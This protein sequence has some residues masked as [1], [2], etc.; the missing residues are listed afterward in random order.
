MLAAFK[1]AQVILSKLNS[2]FLFIFVFERRGRESVDSLTQKPS[3]CLY[4]PVQYWLHLRWFLVLCH[5]HHHHHQ[6]CIKST[7]KISLARKKA[8][9]CGKRQ[10][11]HGR[12]VSYS[13]L[14]W[15]SPPTSAHTCG[16]NFPSEDQ[17]GLKTAAGHIKPSCVSS[18]PVIILQGHKREM[19]G[20]YFVGKWP[21]T[22]SAGSHYLFIKPHTRVLL[23]L[24]PPTVLHI[25][26]DK[27][28]HRVSMAG[29]PQSKG[30]HFPWWIFDC[31][32][33]LR[34][35]IPV[36]YATYSIVTCLKGKVSPI[37]HNT[38]V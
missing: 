19:Q 37:L 28:M 21:L 18:C 2:L 16:L 8:H 7:E 23:V 33:C 25:E 26:T 15:L 13:V 17:S 24:K 12:T 27:H 20:Q 35:S 10:Y 3:V 11:K 29:L 6:F 4:D 32:N 5:H 1:K 30:E 31:R 38:I 36:S 14:I 9:Q 34:L 22:M